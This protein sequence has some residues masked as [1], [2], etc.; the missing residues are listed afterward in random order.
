[1]TEPEVPDEP[2]KPT[3]WPFAGALAIIVLVLIA[4][5]AF[6][7]FTSSAPSDQQQ[8]GTARSR[9]SLPSNAIPSRNRGSAT[10]TTSPT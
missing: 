4:I 7:S 9:R 6:N 10:S 8:L 3:I 2:D 5:F 1:M